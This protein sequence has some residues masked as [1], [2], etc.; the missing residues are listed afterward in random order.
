MKTIILKKISFVF[1]LLVLSVAMLP[2]TSCGS[3]DDKDEPVSNDASLLIGNWYQSATWTEKGGYKEE[4]ID[5]KNW[6]ISLTFEK[7]GIARTEIREYDESAS[8]TATYTYN[9]KSRII[10]FT[11]SNNQK[12]DAKVLELKASSLILEIQNKKIYYIK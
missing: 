5:R 10:Q 9:S 1:T 2:L 3:E 8:S 6:Y 12:I 7:N 4:T 11:T